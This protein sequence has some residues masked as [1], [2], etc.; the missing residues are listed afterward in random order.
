MHAWI[1]S[2]FASLI[3]LVQ[4]EINLPA[5]PEGSLMAL[6]GLRPPP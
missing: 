6:L 4:L 1:Q 2:L 3:G 5:A